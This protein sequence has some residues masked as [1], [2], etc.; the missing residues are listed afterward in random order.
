[1]TPAVEPP[2]ICGFKN[3]RTATAPTRISAS[4]CIKSRAARLCASAYTKVAIFV[5]QLSWLARN[6]FIRDF[7]GRGGVSRDVKNASLERH[8]PHQRPH[9]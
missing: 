2:V 8:R 9:Q 3:D 7:A 1:M 6:Q 4:I 5:R